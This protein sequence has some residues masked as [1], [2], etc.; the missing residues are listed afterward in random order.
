M[1]RMLNKDLI[2][3][4]S[5]SSTPKAKERLFWQGGLHVVSNK[6]KEL[7]SPDQVIVFIAYSK[8]SSLK[9]YVF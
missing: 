4:E 8:G 5:F 7:A 9:R 3:A 2:K 1:A 6:P